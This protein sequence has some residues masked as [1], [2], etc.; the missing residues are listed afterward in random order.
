MWNI[1]ST[2]NRQIG[3]TFG[4]TRLSRKLSLVERNGRKFEIT[5]MCVYDENFK[6]KIFKKSNF[7]FEKAKKN[8][9]FFL[10]SLKLK[11]LHLSRKLSLVQQ[12]GAKF[13]ITYIS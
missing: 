4:S 13:E 3:S 10:K 12:K 6:K 1:G 2:G 8:I 11:L 9:F 7:F 5:Y